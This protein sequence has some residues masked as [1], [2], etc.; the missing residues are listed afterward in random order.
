VPRLN[1]FSSC[2]KIYHR[3]KDVKLYES[4]AIHMLGYKLDFYTPFHF[5]EFYFYNGIIF[6]EI[7]YPIDKIYAFIYDILNCFIFDKK[8]INYTPFQIATACLAYV[9]ELLN[10]N[11]F[12]VVYN[13]KESEYID[14]LNYLKE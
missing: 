2:G 13:I 3:L 1:D 5:V 8:S 7:E 12:F 14:A 11:D 6:D 10:S 4:V 9:L